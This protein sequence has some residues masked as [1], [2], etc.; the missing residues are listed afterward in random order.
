SSKSL[1]S[2][3][4][5][6]GMP[7]SSTVASATALGSLGSDATASFSQASNRAKGSLFSVKSPLVNPL[8]DI[9]TKILPNGELPRDSRPDRTQGGTDSKVEQAQKGSDAAN[10]MPICP[11]IGMSCRSFLHQQP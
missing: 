5:T 4:R 2:T 3:I 10:R 6:L 7:F 11:D 8:S 1:S 9:L